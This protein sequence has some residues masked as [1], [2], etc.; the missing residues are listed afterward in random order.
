MPRQK[1]T[2]LVK[3][4]NDFTGSAKAHQTEM[5]DAIACFADVFF[6]EFGIK[7]NDDVSTLTLYSSEAFA[8]E[9]ANTKGVAQVESRTTG[10]GFV[11]PQPA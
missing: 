8:K 4:S 2:Y 7:T 3:L 11:V 10:L 9:I 6:E 5:A 1:D